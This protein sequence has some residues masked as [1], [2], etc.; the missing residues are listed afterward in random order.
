MPEVRHNVCCSLASWLGLHLSATL[1]LLFQSDSATS[2]GSLM[3]T[4]PPSNSDASVRLSQS[5]CS[6][7]LCFMACP[8]RFQPFRMDG[9]PC[10][11]RVQAFPRPRQELHGSHSG[12][13]F[14][15][16]E[17]NHSAAQAMSSAAVLLAL[18]VPH[19]KNGTPTPAGK[20]YSN[21]SS[22][23]SRLLVSRPGS[24]G[25]LQSSPAVVVRRLRH[26]PPATS[27][28]RAFC[29]NVTE[30]PV[31]SAGAFARAQ[32]F[33]RPASWAEAPMYTIYATGRAP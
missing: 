30:G 32:L 3:Y 13:S 23:E 12:Q 4:K 17:A 24:G 1:L 9:I 25:I 15:L 18:S 26:P 28:L 7:Q 29:E 27:D 11:K 5:S 10:S 2:N 22:S 33:P 14:T 6:T 31:Q 8:T 21:Q 19:P 16:R 20:G